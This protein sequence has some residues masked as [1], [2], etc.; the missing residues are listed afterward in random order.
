MNTSSHATNMH[1][2]DNAQGGGPTNGGD[3]QKAKIQKFNVPYGPCPCAP[4]G[5]NT[6]GV[7]DVRMSS[8]NGKTMDKSRNMGGCRVGTTCI[9]TLGRGAQTFKQEALKKVATGQ[10]TIVDWD[11]IKDDPPPQMKVSPIAAISHKSKAFRS[12]IDLSFL[13]CLR[14]ASEVASCPIL[15]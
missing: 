6:P 5:T 1:L 7:R 12:I 11:T 10:A 3:N 14:D 15:H 9:G 4:R 13:L 8:K 2:L